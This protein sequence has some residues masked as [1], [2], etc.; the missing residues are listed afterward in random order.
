MVE[1]SEKI[2]EHV[3]ETYSQV[4]QR[5]QASCGCG[6][7]TASTASCCGPV[8]KDAYV[9]GIGYSLEDIKELPESAVGAAA[10]CGNPTAIAGL[11][12]GEVVLDLGSGGGIDVFLSAKKVGP[13][14][15]AIGVDMTDEMLNLA[16]K[17]AEEL[18][19]ENV[20]FRKGDIEDLPVEDESVDVIISNCVINLAPDKDK[21]FREAYRVLRPGG[22]ITVSDIVTDGPLPQEIK[23]NPDAWAACVSGAL[24]KEEYLQ[25]IRDAGFQDVKVLD[26]RGFGLVYSAEVEAFKGAHG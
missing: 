22:R 25:K 14:G 3:R 1:N 16:R 11:K 19:F 23:D 12:E 26:C 6:C 4:A 10:G 2:K 24:D 20:E 7:G 8:S 17:N 21:V 9:Q 15:K 18:G 13:K 5:A